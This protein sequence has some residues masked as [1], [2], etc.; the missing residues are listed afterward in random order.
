MTPPFER[1]DT[2]TDFASDAEKRRLAGDPQAAFEIAEEGLASAPDDERCRVALTLALLDLGDVS[3]AREELASTL[4]S[5]RAEPVE[6]ELSEF[7]SEVADV[8]LD[9]AFA[10]AETNPDEMMDANRVVEQTLRDEEAGVAEASFDVTE[11]PT[12]ATRTMA[13]LLESQGAADQAD[14][15]RASLSS[16]SSASQDGTVSQEW[17]LELAEFLE[18]EKDAPNDEAD[19]IRVVTTL[20][21]WLYNLRRK[22]DAAATASR[23]TP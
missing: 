11:H 7:D 17:P 5:T 2:G 9:S 18:F 12:F 19:R 15:V 6:S 8:E 13:D 20:E 16:S 22:P 23:G 10:E 21:S 14:A 3:R 4:A 1:E